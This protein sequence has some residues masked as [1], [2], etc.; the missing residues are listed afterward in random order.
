MALVVGVRMVRFCMNFEVRVFRICRIQDL[1]DMRYERERRVNG[2]FFNV[3][4][5]QLIF[6]IIVVFWVFIWFFFE[7]F[8]Y[9]CFFDS[10]DGK[11]W[12]FIQFF[13]VLMENYFYV[14]GFVIYFICKIVKIV[15]LFL[16]II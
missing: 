10:M 5:I 14:Y 11:F 15:I 9:Y 16:S 6:Y 1:L 13:F 8:Y 12:L 4:F 2:D 3:D 7:V